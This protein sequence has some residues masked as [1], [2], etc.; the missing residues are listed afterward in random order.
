M[1]DLVSL[2][3]QLRIFDLKADI[4]LACALRKGKRERYSAASK[5]GWASRLRRR[6]AALRAGPLRVPSLRAAAADAGGGE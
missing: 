5:K 1:T 6:S 4:E 3:E 2:S